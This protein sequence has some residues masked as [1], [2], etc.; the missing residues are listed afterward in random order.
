MTLGTHDSITVGACVLPLSQVIPGLI[1]PHEGGGSPRPS[2]LV[3][4]FVARGILT[5]RSRPG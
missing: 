4:R 5:A 1:R 3:A 2:T